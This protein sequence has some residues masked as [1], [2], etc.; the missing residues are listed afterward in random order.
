MVANL[1]DVR[2]PLGVGVQHPPQQLAD[3]TGP[4][5]PAVLG[6]DEG[7]GPVHRTVLELRVVFEEKHK[8]THSQTVHVGFLRVEALGL[9]GVILDFGRHEVWRAPA[10]VGGLL[11]I[12]IEGRA[13]VTDADVEELVKQDVVDLQVHVG[14]TVSVD[15][16]HCVGDL[17]ELEAHHSFIQHPAALDE[18]HQSFVSTVVSQQI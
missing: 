15:E 16:G 5:A 8:Q 9:V 10:L 2:S 13:E 12:E 7:R 18:R 17:E 4:T 14:E 3:G 1:V 11:A 6:H